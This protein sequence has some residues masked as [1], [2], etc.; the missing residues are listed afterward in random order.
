MNEIPKKLQGRVH[1]QAWRDMGNHVKKLE[2]AKAQKKK[3]ALN[4]L[5]SIVKEEVHFGY[6]RLAVHGGY[7]PGVRKICCICNEHD[8]IME[9][10]PDGNWYCQEHKHI[11]KADPAEKQNIIN[12]IRSA[13]C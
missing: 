11:W 9:N 2:E 5:N 3:S 1:P 12:E 6:K 10:M 4:E 8:S 7:G 13:L